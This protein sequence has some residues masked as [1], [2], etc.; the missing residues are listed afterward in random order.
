ML[1][2][3]PKVSRR[4]PLAYTVDKECQVE[5]LPEMYAAVLGLRRTGYF[6]EVG[7]MDG[8][9]HSNTC[10]LADIGWHGVYIEATDYYSKKCSERH[11]KNNVTVLR[12]AISDHT[13]TLRFHIANALTTADALSERAYAQMEWS[14][15][16]LHYEYEYVP[17]TTLDNTLEECRA[18]IG[19]D[20]LV[21]DVEGHE[22]QVLDGFSINK[23]KP[24][25]IIIEIQDEHPDFLALPN[26]DEFLA[27]F[28][29]VRETIESAG[30]SLL[31]KN[32]VNS[33]Y[34]ANPSAPTQTGNRRHIDGSF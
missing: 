8:Q 2:F 10:G 9:S 16:L 23:W 27:R 14:R 29:K 33:V 1:S 6:V 19:F 25:M 26:A 32:I 13:G 31:F 21:I 15:D 18:P 30:Y 22:Q 20:V 7:A 11:A 17:C 34:V 5:N 28:K 24:K 4:A 3:L 12:R